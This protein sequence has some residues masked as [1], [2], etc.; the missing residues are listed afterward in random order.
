VTNAYQDFSLDRS[1]GDHALQFT[2]EPIPVISIRN[3][4]KRVSLF[5]ILPHRVFKPF[6]T[7]SEDRAVVGFIELLLSN[8]CGY[9][10]SIATEQVSVK[11]LSLLQVLMCL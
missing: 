8:F 4:Q 5:C 6:F 3:L 10:N 7:I 1:F 9:D 11:H 2:N